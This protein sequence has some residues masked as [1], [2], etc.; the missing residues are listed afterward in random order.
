MPSESFQISVF[1]NPATNYIQVDISNENESNTDPFLLKVVSI[2]G[3]EIYEEEMD[4]L[5]VG[6]QFK[7]IDFADDVKGIVIVTITRGA[8]SVERKVLVQ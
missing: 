6:K 1:P 5:V 4:G 3:R 8:Y 2:D 7:K